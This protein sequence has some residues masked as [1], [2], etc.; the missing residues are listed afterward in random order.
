MQ[1]QHSPQQLWRTQFDKQFTDK[2][3]VDVM[4]QAAWLIRQ[5]ERDTPWRDLLGVDDRLNN[6][7]VKLLD[8]RLT[9]EPE[10][11]NLDSFLLWAIS[12][13]MSHEVRDA[14]KRPQTSIDD[15]TTNQERLEE[16]ASEAIAAQRESKREGV[17]EPSWSLFVREMRKHA[18][19]DVG[20]LAIVDSYANGVTS[21]ADVMKRTG[22]SKATYHAAYQRM[23][24]VAKKLDPEI[25]EIIVQAIA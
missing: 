18:A 21:R 9:W 7:L 4:K 2:L 1:A 23:V 6:V 10:R 22:M 5:V 19:K 16:Q 15:E 17:T 11:V 20:V 24:R 12:R 25:L 8:D 13:E 3:V 14:Q